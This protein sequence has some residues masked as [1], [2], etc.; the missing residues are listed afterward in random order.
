M[1][2]RPV[3]P[4]DQTLEVD[5]PAYRVYYWTGF[6]ECDEWELAEADL[7]EV[8][9]WST[10]TQPAARTASGWS[11]YRDA[12]VELVRLRG[13][14]PQP[15]QTSGRLGLPRSARRPPPK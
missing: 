5:D 15:R 2:A 3:D 4:T 12:E 13:I 8:L 9:A 10:R 11:L 1:R 7:D 14:D 6:S